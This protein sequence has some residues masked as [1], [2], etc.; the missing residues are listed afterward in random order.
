MSAQATEPFAVGDVVRHPYYLE[1]QGYAEMIGRV[2][3]VESVESRPDSKAYWYV[4]V[5]R[6][7]F[8]VPAGWFELVPTETAPEQVQPHADATTVT[9]AP[10]SQGI[11]NRVGGHAGPGA[12]SKPAACASCGR[13]P[14]PSPTLDEAQAVLEEA[15]EAERAAVATFLHCVAGP[16]GVVLHTEAATFAY[17]ELRP[18]VKATLAAEVAVDFAR[19]RADAE[20]KVSA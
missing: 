4:K 12:T 6:L 1:P 14:F 18:L 13:S 19:K 16:E 8:P 9:P 10:V 17:Y 3:V 5:D 20:A 2:A 15:S 7:P 11:E